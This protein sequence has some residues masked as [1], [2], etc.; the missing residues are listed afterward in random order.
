MSVQVQMQAPLPVLGFDLSTPR[1]VV[2]LAFPDGPVRASFNEEMTEHLAWLMP[3]VHILLAEA[4][5]RT[6]DLGAIAVGRGPG[7]FTGVR[8]AVVTAKSMAHVLGISLVAPSSLD[9][10]AASITTEGDAVCACLDARRG[11]LYYAFYV[12]EEGEPRLDG[13]RMVGPPSRM[14]EDC[15]T[16]LDTGSRRLS[17]AGNGITA[18]E[19]ILRE[20]LAGRVLFARELY[21]GG[22]EIIAVAHRML[23][24]YETVSPLSLT[25]FYLR[26]PDSGP[27]AGGGC[28]P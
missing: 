19:K 1:A 25:P 18:Y 14:I 12:I 23:E 27:G 21:P 7:S 13:E 16:F 26:L 5:L 10:L 17:L 9:L 8:T 2:A 11:E 22:E 24:R 4:G 28:N 6:A 20:E 3:A 15:R